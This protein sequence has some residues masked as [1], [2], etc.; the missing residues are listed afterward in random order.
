MC[1]T[2]LTYFEL[3]FISAIIFQIV[4]VENLKNYHQIGTL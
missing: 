1:E 4:E 3:N 2:E